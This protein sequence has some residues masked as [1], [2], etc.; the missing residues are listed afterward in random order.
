MNWI[1]FE[2]HNWNF[3]LKKQLKIKRIRNKLKDKID[4]NDWNKKIK[5]KIEKIKKIK[6]IRVKF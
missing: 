4:S 6:I 5:K 2:G 1:K 3:F